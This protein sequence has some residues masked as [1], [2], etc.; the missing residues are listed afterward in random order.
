V[1]LPINNAG[2]GSMRRLVDED[3]HA[4]LRAIQIKTASN[5]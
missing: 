1:D 3:C 2:V 5:Q 4:V